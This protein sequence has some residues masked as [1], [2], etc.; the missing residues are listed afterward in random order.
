VEKKKSIAY[1]PEAPVVSVTYVNNEF[2]QQREA[3][4][5]ELF[6]NG[7]VGVCALDVK[8]APRY[9]TGYRWT[10]VGRENCEPLNDAARELLGAQS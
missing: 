6:G 7:I 2:W 8:G 9:S 4:I 10:V 1:P 3:V 5:V